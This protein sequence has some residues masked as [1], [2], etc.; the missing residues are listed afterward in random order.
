M[1]VGQRRYA[2]TATASLGWSPTP[3]RF[4]L[5]AVDV[6]ATHFFDGTVYRLQDPPDGIDAD[7]MARL[8][9]V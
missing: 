1:H 4:H 3:G 7:L 9:L 6:A 5:F 8:G 2:D